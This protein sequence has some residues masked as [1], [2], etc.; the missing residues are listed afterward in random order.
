MTNTIAIVLGLM[1]IAA[2]AA[3]YILTGGT[4]LVFL[5]IKFTEFTEW[6]AFWR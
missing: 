6:L 2:I 4:N 5:A 3:D 1:I